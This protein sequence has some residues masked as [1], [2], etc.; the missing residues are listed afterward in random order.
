MTNIVFAY[1]VS[2]VHACLRLHELLQPSSI[3]LVVCGFVDLLQPLLWCH[4]S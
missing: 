4:V 2:H 3:A 1:C